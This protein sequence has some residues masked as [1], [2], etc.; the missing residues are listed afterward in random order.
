MTYTI[1]FFFRGRG[2]FLG[3]RKIVG[4]LHTPSKNGSI[5]RIEFEHLA[6]VNENSNN[7]Y[8]K[9]EVI[10]TTPYSRELG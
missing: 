7:E 8:G 2:W 6:G 10:G 9:I 5:I 1:L 4:F 3:L